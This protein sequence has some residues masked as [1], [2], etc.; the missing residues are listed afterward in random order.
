MPVGNLW[1]ESLHTEV[2]RYVLTVFSLSISDVFLFHLLNK[3]ESQRR[4]P[5]ARC[6][7]SGR[8]ELEREE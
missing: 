5:L 8:G 2:V 7:V 4:K 3:S 1:P 6:N